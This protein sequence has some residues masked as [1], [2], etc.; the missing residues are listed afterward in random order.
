M[1]EEKTTDIAKVETAPLTI[2]D[3]E[4]NVQ[5]IQKVMQSVMIPKVHYDTIPGCGSKPMLLKP[6]AEKILS[7]FRIGTDLTIEALGDDYDFKYRIVIRG[8]HIPTGNTI[9]YGVGVCSTKE[10]KYAWRRVVCQGEF[11]DA[12]PD[13][14]QNKWNDD[15]S[16]TLQVRQSPPDIENTVLKMAKKRA[17]VDLCLTATACSDIFAQ[18]LDE[19]PGNTPAVQA[20]QEKTTTQPAQNMQ[21]VICGLC[22]SDKVMTPE[23]HSSKSPDYKCFACKAVAWNNNGQLTWKEQKLS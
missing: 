8:F 21:K 19:N 2:A 11:D 22:Q 3:L 12:E 6:G 16:Q 20:P 4:K 10:K 5:V 1:S 15:G 23:K 18:D 14:R 7:V 9:G 17:M 13:K